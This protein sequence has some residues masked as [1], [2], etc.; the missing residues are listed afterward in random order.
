MAVQMP[1]ID[2]TR[3]SPLP[4]VSPGERARPLLRPSRRGLTA[5]ILCRLHFSLPPEGKEREKICKNL[6]CCSSLLESYVD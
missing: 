2:F 5:L 3:L 6:S 4:S 1:K